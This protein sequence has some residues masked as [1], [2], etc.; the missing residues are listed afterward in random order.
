[1]IVAKKNFFKF[2]PNLVHFLNTNS[3]YPQNDSFNLNPTSSLKQSRFLRTLGAKNGWQSSDKR[4]DSKHAIF[5]ES[6]GFSSIMLQRVVGHIRLSFLQCFS[7]KNLYLVDRGQN[8]AKS[9]TV[10]QA[11]RTLNDLPLLQRV[12]LY[13]LVFTLQR[14]YQNSTT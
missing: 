12:T 11:N 4:V 8:V 6:P 1:M 2:L 9:C 3:K 7:T 10:K 5:S 14:E 13:S